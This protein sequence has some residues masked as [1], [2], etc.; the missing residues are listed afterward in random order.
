MIAQPPLAPGPYLRR[1]VVQHRHTR[2]GGRRSELHV[3][4]RIIDENEQRHTSAAQTSF[5]LAQQRPMFGYVLEH[6]YEAHHRK[7]VSMLDELDAGGAHRVSADSDECV[8][9]PAR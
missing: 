3:E 1:D 5:E 4:A 8:L 7:L 9:R 6:F 2:R